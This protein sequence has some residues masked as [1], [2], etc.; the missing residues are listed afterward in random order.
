VYIEGTTPGLVVKEY[1]GYIAGV[2]THYRDTSGYLIGRLSGSIDNGAYLYGIDS[3]Y[4][5]SGGYIAGYLT[6]SIEY[7]SYIAGKAE[8]YADSSS[9]LVGSILAS[10]ENYGIVH[11]YDY[12]NATY[13]AFVSGPV[14][15][16]FY[17]IPEGTPV[18]N[19]H[20]SDNYVTRRADKGEAEVTHTDLSSIIES[21]KS[22]ATDLKNKI[23]GGPG[24]I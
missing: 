24:R 2:D 23:R 18:K 14:P 21:L 11:T 12:S 16:P 13:G 9:Y 6:Y 4:H 15:P 7:Y 10:V 8:S 3:K 17:I 19:W 1:Y 5:D 20:V 22:I